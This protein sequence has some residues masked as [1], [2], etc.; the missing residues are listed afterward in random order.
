MLAWTSE[1][2]GPQHF[3]LPA[4]REIVSF[5][6]AARR[7]H[8]RKINGGIAVVG[9][10]SSSGGRQAARFAFWL[11][12]FGFLAFGLGA[13]AEAQFPAELY[14]KHRISEIGPG[15]PKCRFFKQILSK[16]CPGRQV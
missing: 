6:V 1:V 4:I 12:A 13:W 14:Y 7:A 15:A 2:G 3:M 8:A 10:L 16:V 5:R 9:P 11:L